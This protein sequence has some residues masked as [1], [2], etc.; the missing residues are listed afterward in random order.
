MPIEPSAMSV[1]FAAQA[2]ASGS[3]AAEQVADVFL[4][5]IERLDPT[6]RTFL[7]VDREAVL[8][9]ARSIDPEAR[10]RR[11]AGALGRRA[12]CGQRFA[13]H[14]RCSPP[15]APRR[16][17]CATESRGVRRMTPPWCRACARPARSWW[18]RR[19]STS[20]PWAPPPK[21]APCR[22]PRT[23]G[24]PRGSRAEALEEARWRFAARLALAALGSDTGGSIRQPAALTHTVG[25]KP[26]YGRVSRYGLVAFAS[27]LDQIGPF[28]LGCARRSARAVG[29]RGEAMSATPP[30][31]A[32][33]SASWSGHADRP[34]RGCASECR[35]STS[36]KGWTRA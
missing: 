33:R 19:T 26:T 31:R 5:R 1:H 8:E 29:H 27:S 7:H 30:A 2:V 23:R 9:S 16:S 4:Q 15:R 11:T 17:W 21:T 36:A 32:C 3:L 34:S 13:V 20:S 14:A 18:A 10:Q 12:G 25:I 35:R 24:T 6:L 22:R 28:A